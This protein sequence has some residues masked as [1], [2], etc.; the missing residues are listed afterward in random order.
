MRLVTYNCYVSQVLLTLGRRG[1]MGD[2]VPGVL[3]SFDITTM[4]FICCADWYTPKTF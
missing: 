2:G 4:I 1:A 3:Q